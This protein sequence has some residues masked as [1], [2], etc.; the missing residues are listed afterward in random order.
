MEL[1]VISRTS[2][3]GCTASNSP[4]LLRLRP[5]SLRK[6]ANAINVI[7]RN[8]RNRE[9]DPRTA[10]R[11]CACP[12]VSFTGC[13]PLVVGKATARVPI[14]RSGRNRRS[15]VEELMVRHKVLQSPGARAVTASNLITHLPC[16]YLVAK[17]LFGILSL[18]SCEPGNNAHDRMG[19]LCL[20]CCVVS[21]YL[22]P[23]TL[24]LTHRYSFR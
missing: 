5:Q 2:Q 22:L 23:T 21:S 17:N 4:W 19:V 11:F 1:V 24:S 7:R 14:T 16:L 13:I 8:S 20:L 12:V 3:K 10:K 9:G 18:P 6:F 15:I